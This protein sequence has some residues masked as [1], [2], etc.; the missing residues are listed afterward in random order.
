MA[1][2][3]ENFAE[4]TFKPMI[5]LLSDMVV[6]LENEKRKQRQR[7]KEDVRKKRREMFK[8]RRL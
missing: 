6:N 5:E 7:V 3:L 2:G 1:T 4:T 8:K